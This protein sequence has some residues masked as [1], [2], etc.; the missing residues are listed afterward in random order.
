[1]FSRSLFHC[2][3]NK[4]VQGIK[5]MKYHYS[6]CFSVH[7]MSLWQL[8]YLPVTEVEGEV[9]D[10]LKYIQETKETM[11]QNTKKLAE[12]QGGIK[13]IHSGKMALNYLKVVVCFSFKTN[14]LLLFTY[15]P[16]WYFYVSANLSSYNQ[17][18]F[19]YI[20]S[21]LKNWAAITQANFQNNE[22]MN[23]WMFSLLLHI[24]ISRQNTTA[25]R[26]HLEGGWEDSQSLCRGSSK[27]DPNHQQSGRVG[28]QH[29]KQ[30][31]LYCCL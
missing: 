13:E 25:T 9:V 17:N 29:D 31:I 16:W 23:E 3:Q 27:H 1:M 10:K 21:S 6:K 8:L 20:F 24:S 11:D 22:W 12:I 2:I 19:I 18:L 5:R 4:L 28:K 30:W 7:Q 26:V 15:M 14:K